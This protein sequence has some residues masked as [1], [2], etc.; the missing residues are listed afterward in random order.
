[1]NTW[2]STREEEAL[3]RKPPA[4]IRK[5]R[6]WRWLVLFRHSRQPADR[7]LISSSRRADLEGQAAGSRP[8]GHRQERKIYSIVAHERCAEVEG[9]PYLVGGA[10]LCLCVQHARRAHCPALLRGTGSCSV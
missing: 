10:R 1:M 7:Q 3:G 9:I 4:M 5:R 2:T 6:V 8:T